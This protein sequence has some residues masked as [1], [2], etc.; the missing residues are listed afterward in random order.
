MSYFHRRD[1]GMGG[2]G[3]DRQGAIILAIL[4][5][6]AFQLRTG[7]RN[8]Q[9]IPGG[10]ILDLPARR[11]HNGAD[12]ARITGYD[13]RYMLEI[14]KRNGRA[15][16]WIGLADD[17]APTELASQFDALTGLGGAP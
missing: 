14:I 9:P 4:G 12:A 3:N 16:R 7:A 17:I 8:P 13:D 6:A 15:F 2:T 11:T 10:L 5:G 1:R